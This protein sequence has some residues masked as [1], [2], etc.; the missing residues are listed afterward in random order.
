MNA[1]SYAASVGRRNA[2]MVALT[3]RRTLCFKTVG[4]TGRSEPY[5]NSARAQSHGGIEAYNEADRHA[6]KT[7]SPTQVLLQIKVVTRVL[8]PSSCHKSAGRTTFWLGTMPLSLSTSRDCC[9]N[10]GV[11][12]KTASLLFMIDAT[13]TVSLGGKRD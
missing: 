6:R 1:M 10:V 8:V 13:V 4:L 5:Q 2:G 9:V 7:V 3:A 11:G 12:I